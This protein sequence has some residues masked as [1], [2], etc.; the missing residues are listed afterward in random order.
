M[1]REE[2]LA[3][4]TPLREKLLAARER[5]DRPLVDDKVLT[6]W[7][8]TAIA[9]LAVAGRELGDDRMIERAA[10]VAD[11]VLSELRS[12]TLL[13]SWRRGQARRR[14]SLN[15]SSTAGNSLRQYV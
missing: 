15:H 5:R 6:D 10:R 12:E 4:V 9:G 3:E 8:G 1:D 13:H 11:F 7:N 2:L 14:S